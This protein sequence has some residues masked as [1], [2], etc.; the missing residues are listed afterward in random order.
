MKT[1]RQREPT[2]ATARLAEAH[3]ERT[4]NTTTPITVTNWLAMLNRLNP[5]DAD[6]RA[7]RVEDQAE[8]V[9]QGVTAVGTRGRRLRQ[10]DALQELEQARLDR[11][12]TGSSRTSCRR[13]SPRTRSATA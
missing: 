9:H 12:S 7:I 13:A 8:H 1:R 2:S 5:T 3:R 4:S 10:A 6:V 11:R